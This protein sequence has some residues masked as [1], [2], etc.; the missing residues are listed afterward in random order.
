M[1]NLKDRIDWMGAKEA[2]MREYEEGLRLVK[3]N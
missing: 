3:R 2:E 1:T